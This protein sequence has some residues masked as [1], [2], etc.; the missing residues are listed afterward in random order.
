MFN[1]VT[2]E[3]LLKVWVEKGREVEEV[4]SFEFCKIIGELLVFILFYGISIEV[5]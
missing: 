4:K 2:E 5:V 3:Y 1:R